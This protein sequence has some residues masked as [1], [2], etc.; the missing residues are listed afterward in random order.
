MQLYILFGDLPKH[1]SSVRCLESSNS[2]GCAV[3]KCCQLLMAVNKE[4]FTGCLG[5][6]NSLLPLERGDPVPFPSCS[7]SFFFKLNS[8][9]AIHGT[10]GG[11]GGSAM[12]LLGGSG[13]R[14]Q[15]K[16]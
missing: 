3:G 5:Q 14:K 15:S 8:L 13:G 7:C 11:E 9:R 16:G 10:K 4:N 6:C 2:H 1:L 12:K